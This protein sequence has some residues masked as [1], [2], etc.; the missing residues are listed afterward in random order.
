VDADVTIDWDDACAGAIAKVLG[1][2][3]HLLER[4][5]ELVNIKNWLALTGF[6]KDT[7]PKASTTSKKCKIS[8]DY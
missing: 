6:R 4:V 2:N 8:E 7:W 1:S 5:G 3:Q